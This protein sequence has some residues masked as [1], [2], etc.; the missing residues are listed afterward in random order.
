MEQ[1]FKYDTLKSAVE[2]FGLFIS[3]KKQAHEMV[4]YSY[5]DQYM[6][7]RFAQRVRMEMLDYYKDYAA[8]LGE[9]THEDQQKA[10]F[11]KHLNY[12]SDELSKN[13]KVEFYIVLLNYTIDTEKVSNRKEYIGILYERLKIVANIFK[14]EESRMESLA[15][16]IG[17]NLS[18]EKDSKRLIVIGNFNRVK[19]RSFRM[20]NKKDIKGKIV[21]LYVPS[22]SSFLIRYSGSHELHLNK[23]ILFPERVYQFALGG[24]IEAKGMSPIYFADLFADFRKEDT[25]R[26]ELVAQGVEKN[27]R[28][29]NLGVKKLSFKVKSGQLMAVMGRSGTGKTT[30]FNIL[31]GIAKPNSGNVFLNG[32]NL[33]ENIDKLKRHLGYVPQEDLLIEELT[34]FQN[35]KFGAQLCRDDL[36]EN[37]IEDLVLKTL[38]DFGLH[39]IKN[40]RVGSPL[41][42]VIS[43]GQRKRLN[44]ALE[45]IRRP[46]VL[47]V[48][49]PTSGLSSSDALLVIKLLKQIAGMGNI[50]IINIHQPPSDLFMLFDKLLILDENGYAAFYGNPFSASSYFKKHLEF[51]DS[52]N[53][54]SLKFGQCNPEQVINLLE[55]KNLSD[56]GEPT[57]DR[58]Y[59]STQWHRLFTQEVQDDA[60]LKY[61]ELDVSLTTIPNR[62]KQFWIYL[63]RNVQIRKSD[64]QYLAMIFLGSP[65]LA[66]IMAFFLK[67]TDLET[68]TYR[69]IDNENL[70]VYLFISVVVSL[71]LGLILSSGE[72]YRDLK[73][74]KREGFLNLSPSSYLNSKVVYVALVNA[75]QIS[76][77]VLAG[78]SIM[79]IKGLYL[80]YFVVLWL[81]AFSSSM[82]GLYISAK[83]KS[84]LSIYI[85]IPFLLIPQIL[86]AGAILDFDKVHHSLASKKYVPVYAN[87]NISRW[88]Y[89]ALV[90]LQFTENEYDKG[91]T[92]L[93]VKQSKMSY[94]ANFFV[95]KIE[96]L[97]SHFNQTADVN[98]EV[99][100]MLK[101]LMTQFPKLKKEVSK[102]KVDQDNIKEIQQVV[103][104]VKKWLRLNLNHLYEKVEEQR[105]T[106]PN[107]I[108]KKDFFNQKLS[109]FIL[110]SSDYVKYVYSDGEMI[111]KFQPGYYVSDN[112][113][114]R[115]HY[116]APRK[117]IGKMLVATWVYNLAIMV[118][119]ALFFY[120][121]TYVHL[122]RNKF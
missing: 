21:A 64:T 115:S 120:A 94:H 83:F 97:L 67:S 96:T 16:F 111:R 74:I 113:F 31:S 23:Q 2:L 41:D 43:G 98:E 9:G 118:V 106:K 66:C 86:L 33:H 36:S 78:N 32:H 72:I 17:D 37:E 116:Y 82:M 30:L 56:N 7:S 102:V 14:L 85:T 95:P 84:I 92:D 34:V 18:M 29:T 15:H 93:L 49:E 3:Y 51:V 121:A 8:T 100:L 58:V 4:N 69:F 27:F 71:F 35:L 52:I 20:Y 77:Y 87:I 55:Y 104:K 91:L 6:G 61:N 73:V 48:D 5:L 45:L 40:L 39:N 105:K 88:A 109:D 122:K 107:N 26:L 119:F 38:F 24:V 47:F 90:V 22:I 110:K 60:S 13:Q 75:V 114:G 80:P 12:L 62:I 53:D 79:E 28:D 117:R 112:T 101:E 70:P 19:L 44:I 11:N 68:H 46:D 10:T 50:V 76:L 25:D 63:K 108:V 42:K 57:G 99:E 65:V 54:D 81:T 103:S 59:E 89:E 1:Y